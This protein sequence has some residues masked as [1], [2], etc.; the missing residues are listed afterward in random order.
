M[1]G[2]NSWLDEIEDILKGFKLPFDRFYKSKNGFSD[3]D[4]VVGD[5]VKCLPKSVSTDDYL[6]FSYF[7]KMSIAF[8]EAAC[9]EEDKC[10][11]SLCTIA[12]IVTPRDDGKVTFTVMVEQETNEQHNNTTEKFF[13]ACVEAHHAFFERFPKDFDGTRF[14]EIVKVTIEEFMRQKGMWITKEQFD[15]TDLASV[16]DWAKSSF[17]RGHYSVVEKYDE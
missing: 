2:L 13:A 10:F 14:K 1:C 11:N 4:V 6:L 17:V 7:F 9:P 3:L 8:L 16:L 15:K 5:L 12:G